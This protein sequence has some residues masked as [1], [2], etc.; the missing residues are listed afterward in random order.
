MQDLL[1]IA[2]AA[3]AAIYL[4]RQ[5]WLRLSRKGGSCGSCPS[6]SADDSIKSRPLV[7][8]TLDAPRK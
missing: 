5:M 1:A 6:C 7:N 2:I 3:V 8:I 4:A